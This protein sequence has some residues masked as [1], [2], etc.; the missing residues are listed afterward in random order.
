MIQIK[1]KLVISDILNVHFSCDYSSCLGVCCVHGDTGAPLEDFE[2]EILEKEFKN[3]KCFISPEGLATIE[4]QGMWIFDDD[5]DKVTPLIEGNECAY[6]VFL[7]G[8]AKC[9]IEM[10]NED[11][12]TTFQKPRSCHLYPIRVSKAGDY[13]VLN[14]HNWS[15]CEPARTKGKREGIPLFRFL[16]VP[17]IKNWGKEFYNE[18]EDVYAEITR[19]NA[20]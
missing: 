3:I 7:N 1:D 4:K 17:I 8:I 14:Y 11:K 16:K 12:K 2:T 6:A 20:V 18:L 19:D 13:T 9:S 5:G 15:I 10:A